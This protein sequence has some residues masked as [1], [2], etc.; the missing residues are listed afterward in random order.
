MLLPASRRMRMCCL[1][2]T[3][4]PNRACL[5]L[6]AISMYVLNYLLGHVVTIIVS[7]SN[8]INILHTHTLSHA[9]AHALRSHSIFVLF[10]IL[11]RS[12]FSLGFASFV[13]PLANPRT[14]PHI[15]NSILCLH[16]ASSSFDGLVSCIEGDVAVAV[17]TTRAW[18]NIMAKKGK[19][20]NER[21]CWLQ[22]CDIWCWISH[23][24]AVMS[25]CVD[26]R[27]RPFCLSFSPFTAS[28]KS[29]E[30]SNSERWLRKWTKN[31]RMKWRRCA[32]FGVMKSKLIRCFG[33]GNCFNY[34]C[35]ISRFTLASPQLAPTTHVP[36]NSKCANRSTSAS[37]LCL[38]IM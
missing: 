29:K 38:F 9:Q 3:A 7:F 2:I 1:H 8:V 26:A 5:I 27:A 33:K 17:R 10:R 28:I 14:R 22:K 34:L 32:F 35:D 30:A 25:P 12:F 37:R 6:Y 4:L 23:Q 19:V 18:N 24:Y 11:H 21:K 15:P 31:V 16:N 36:A 13:P 20:N